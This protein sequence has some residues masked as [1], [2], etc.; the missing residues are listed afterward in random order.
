MKCA[1]ETKAKADKSHY[2]RCPD[3]VTHADKTKSNCPK[4]KDGA[5]RSNCTKCPDTVT[6]T[7]L[8]VVF[9]QIKLP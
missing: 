5:T 2:P 9:V 8:F 4:C 1:D 7:D 6:E 3:G